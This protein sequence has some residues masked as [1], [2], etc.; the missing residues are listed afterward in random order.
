MQVVGYNT[1]APKVRGARG[2]VGGQVARQATS[3]SG[4]S[5]GTPGA[6]GDFWMANGVDHRFGDSRG[7]GPGVHQCGLL[8]TGWRGGISKNKCKRRRLFR[9]RKRAPRHMGCRGGAV[10]QVVGAVP[11]GNSATQAWE[12]GPAVLLRRRKWTPSIVEKARCGFRLC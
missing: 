8:T 1:A 3:W 9:W 4:F 7:R 2:L 11:L 10:D 12:G 6:D 5:P